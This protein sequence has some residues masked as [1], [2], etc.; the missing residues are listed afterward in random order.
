MDTAFVSTFVSSWVE[1]NRETIRGWRRHLHSH[2]ELSHMEMSTTQFILDTLRAVGLDPHPLPATGATVDIGPVDKPL[3]A[4]RGDID[5]LPI[6]EE[7]GLDFASEMPGVM[8]A[9]GHDI[10]TTVVLALACGLKAYVDAHGE[11]ALPVRV[12][13]IFQPAEEVMDGGAVEVI[14]A[15]ALKDVQSIFAVHCEPKLRTGEIGVRTGPITSASDVVEIVLRGPGGHTSRPHLTTDLIYATGKIITELPGL[16]SRR[17]DPRSGTVVTFGAVNG[18]ATFNAIPQEVRLLGTFRTAQVGVWREGE[19]ILRELVEDIVAP[20][21][22]E[23]EIKYTKG[24][25]PVT[26]DDVATA[27]IAQAVKDT[28]PHALR[29]APQSSGGEDFSWYLEHVPGS[30]ARLGSWNGEGEKPDLHQPDIIFDERAIGVGIR[31]FAGVIEQFREFADAEGL[32][33][34]F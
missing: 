24:V 20:T 8:H 17:I 25:P 28:D 32:G 4:F 22:A 26:N 9:C 2:P 3:I 33:S 29:E 14:A 21:N 5:A 10:H 13:V 34:A 1:E 12:R 6:T 19:K 11:D 30:M 15:G 16:L 23:L 27:L 7:T 18:G 31:L